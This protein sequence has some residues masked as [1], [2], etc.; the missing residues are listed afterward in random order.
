MQQPMHV[1][2]MSKLRKR[3]LIVLCAALLICVTV[4]GS[5]TYAWLVHRPTPQ[6][7]TLKG[8][9]LEITIGNNNPKSNQ[10]MVPGSKITGVD[11]RIIAS[12][13]SN[14][15]YNIY[16]KVTKSADFDTYFTY[17]LDSRW[18]QVATEGT[19][20]YLRHSQL[21]TD[22]DYGTEALAIFA[23][24]QLTVKSTIEKSTTFASAAPSVTVKAC[25]VQSD[26]ISLD[27]QL[28]LAKA[29]LQ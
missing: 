22:S 14:I 6:L 12:A 2:P 15:N 4:G 3:W 24:D 19:T 11:P 26:A 29:H 23:S 27:D 9:N 25:A 21:L 1:K 10:P 20:V 13:N 18:T 17:S 28:A 8:S 16:A 7:I 5:V